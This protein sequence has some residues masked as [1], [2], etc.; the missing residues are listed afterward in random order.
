MNFND[1]TKADLQK[2]LQD[3]YGIKLASNATKAEYIE[4]CNELSGRSA[5]AVGTGTANE[6][7][8]DKTPVEAIIN[9]HDD[10]DKAMNY[11]TPCWNGVNYQIMKGVNVRVPIAIVNILNKAKETSYNTIRHEDGTTEMRPTEVL[12]FPFTV[13]EYIYG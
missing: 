6:G 10:G 1:M 12:R 9:V 5:S 2:H 11:I 4:R 8:E 3:E 13:V 7:K